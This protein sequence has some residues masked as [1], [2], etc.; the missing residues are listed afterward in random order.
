VVVDLGV[1]VEWQYGT[2]T[3]KF[4]ETVRLSRRA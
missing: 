1:D 4:I 2:G 3:A